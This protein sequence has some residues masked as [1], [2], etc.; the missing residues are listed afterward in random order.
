MNTTRRSTILCYRVTVGVLLAS[1][2]SV[3]LAY[4]LQ[5]VTLKRAEK[6]AIKYAIALD[7]A[8]FRA[9]KNEAAVKCLQTELKR[10][11]TAAPATERFVKKF[12]VVY[13]GG[14]ACSGFGGACRTWKPARQEKT[15]R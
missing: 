4:Y 3:A 15:N 11:R 10:A 2:Y 5:G 7:V 13:V 14:T 8:N 12:T 9:A 1:L 6:R